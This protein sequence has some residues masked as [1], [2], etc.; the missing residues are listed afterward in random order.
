MEPWM[1]AQYTVD[2]FQA[3]NSGTKLLIKLWNF[4]LVG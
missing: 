2:F 3:G 1:T 4:Q